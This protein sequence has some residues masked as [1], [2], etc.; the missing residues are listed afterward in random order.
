MRFNTLDEWLSWQETLHPK[1]ID[2][3]LGRVAKV[4]QQLQPEPLPFLVI[5][6]AGT[7]GK[8]SSVAMLESILLAAGY[9]VGTYTSPHLLQYNERIRIQ[10]Q[11]VDDDS[12]CDAFQRIDTARGN[13]SLTYF[14]FGTL[15]ALDLFARVTS[16]HVVILEVGMGGRLDATNIVAANVALI[17]RI[18]MDHQ[19]WL[20]EDRDTIAKEKA[21]IMRT[22][23]PA[24]CSD[25]AVPESLLECAASKQAPLYC[26]G[27]AFSY[28]A[29]P[30]EWAWQAG[31]AQRQTLPHPALRGEHQLENA[32]GVLMV[33]SLLAEQLPVG[34]GDI[35]NGLLSVRL[36]GRFQVEQVKV[37]GGQATRVLDV[38]HNPDA[39][40][41]LSQLLAGQPTQGK[42]YAVAA[43][44]ED[45]DIPATLGILLSQIDAWFV[46][47]LGGPRGAKAAQLAKA[48]EPATCPVNCHT[49]VTAAYQDAVG[50][51]QAQD[52]I[53]VFGSFYSV[54]EVMQ[55]GI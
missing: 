3:S 23:L 7:N 30:T 18:A 31:D 15:A 49:S 20:G 13:I 36:P 39:V 38:A 37:K 8:G 24:V 9:K 51:A 35:R 2:L 19:A 52:R 33:L 14:E 25:P 44:L 42:T 5:T 12:L 46:A 45:K 17:T 1:K 28:Q 50:Q 47:D 43:M 21:G 48:L 11:P 40:R 55:Q 27:K 6:V 29:T 26:L 41:S 22:G 16:L 10:G 4:F 34:Q 53:V 54:A 32:A